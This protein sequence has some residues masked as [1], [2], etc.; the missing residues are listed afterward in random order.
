[1]ADK[2]EALASAGIAKSILLIRGQKVLLDRDLAAIYGVTTGRLNEAVKRN[3]ARFPADFM[4]QI[5][6]EELGN[7]RS[8]I[9]ISS[10]GGRRYLPYVFTDYG[11]IQASNILSSPQAIEMGIYVVRAFVHL[12]ET[13]AS[14]K[15]L[16]EQLKALESRMLRKFAAHDHAIADIIKTIR[17]LMIAPETKKRSIGFTELEERKKS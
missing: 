8:Q 16:A 7:L 5:T 15:E 3:I 17:Q 14:S 9:A 13:L 10:W 12:R 4:F 11:A 2:K 6:A 1:M